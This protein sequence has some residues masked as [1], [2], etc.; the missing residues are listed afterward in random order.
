MCPSIISWNDPSDHLIMIIMWKFHAVPQHGQSHK[1][2]TER[3]PLI[4]SKTFTSNMTMLTNTSW[5]SFWKYLLLMQFAY[6]VADCSMQ[7]DLAHRMPDCQVVILFLFVVPPWARECRVNGLS[8]IFKCIHQRPPH[9]YGSRL[10]QL[11]LLTEWE[12]RHTPPSLRQTLL[13]SSDARYQYHGGHSLQLT[14]KK[15]RLNQHIIET[16]LY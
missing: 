13:L 5:A 3:L 15:L 10:N 6:Q 1:S 4:L 16:S 9:N 11:N 8:L 12:Q 14:I 7:V 2:R